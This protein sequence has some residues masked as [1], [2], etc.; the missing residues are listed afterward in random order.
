MNEQVDEEGGWTLEL[1]MPEQD[2]NRFMADRIRD[3]IRKDAAVNAIVLLD[4]LS[5][6]V[7]YSID[8]SL[9]QISYL[10]NDKDE[11]EVA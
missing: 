3:A 4:V 2:L 6:E 11:S 8:D 7:S 10:F 1:E 5:K 9:H